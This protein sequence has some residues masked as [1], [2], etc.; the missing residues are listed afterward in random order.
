MSSVSLSSNLENQVPSLPAPAPVASKK[1]KEASSES[2]S[3]M[4]AILDRMRKQN[5][6]VPLSPASSLQNSSPRSFTLKRKKEKSVSADKENSSPVPG[7]PLDYHYE[8]FYEEANDQLL[9]KVFRSVKGKEFQTIGP[10]DSRKDA[11]IL[12]THYGKLSEKRKKSLAKPSPVKAG[13]D[14]SIELLSDGYKVSR[15]DSARTYKVHENKAEGK[16]AKLSF[17]PHTGDGFVTVAGSE[18]EDHVRT[19]KKE[20]PR[21]VKFL[22]YLELRVGSGSR[23]SESPSPVS[24]STSSS[25]TSLSKK[26][27]M[28]SFR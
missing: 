19:Y 24:D 3:S 4:S 8:D 22:K 27:S 21:D 15:K 17:F 28:L 14:V 25:S 12:Q 9:S 1:R 18:L 23:P 16:A 7:L 11:E 26:P 20:S 13:A 5:S 6:K 2:P 10:A